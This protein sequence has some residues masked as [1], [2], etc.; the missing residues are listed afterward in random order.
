[1]KRNLQTWLGMTWSQVLLLA[2][3]SFNHPTAAAS[4]DD[5]SGNYKIAA[6]SNPGGGSYR[7]TVRINSMGDAL[8]RRVEVGFGRGLRS[9]G[10]RWAA[11]LGGRVGTGGGKHGVVVYRINGGSLQGNG[12]CLICAGG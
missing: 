7:G 12:R 1:M 3:T 11:R 2:S 10:I 5:L 6:S 8:S 4:G 9:V